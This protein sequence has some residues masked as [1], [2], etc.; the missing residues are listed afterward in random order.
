MMTTKT[1]TFL[2]FL[3][4]SDLTLDYNEYKVDKLAA[5]IV[6]YKYLKL[7]GQKD[8]ELAKKTKNVILQRYYVIVSMLDSLIKE[9]KPSN[10]KLLAYVTQV[11]I[12][13]KDIIAI[14]EIFI[15]KNLN[16]I[17]NQ[18][19]NG[20]YPYYEKSEF[21]RAVGLESV[22]ALILTA[23]VVKP[24]LKNKELREKYKNEIRESMDFLY[25]SKSKFVH[26]HEKIIVAHTFAI[27]GNT[28][29]AAE[30]INNLTAKYE[31]SIFAKHKSLYV[32]NISYLSQIK[33]ILGTDP[34]DHIKWLMN[35]RNPNGGFYSP[36]ETTLAL[37][38][39]YEYEKYIRSKKNHVNNLIFE[40]NGKKYEMSNEISVE[41]IE[42]ITS[43]SKIK[44]SGNGLG[45]ASI[46]CENCKEEVNKRSTIFKGN[47]ISRKLKNNDIRVTSNIIMESLEFINV[48]NLV[49]IEFHSPSG[50]QFTKN[51]SKVGDIVVSIFCLLFE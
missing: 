29:I 26:N 15:H 44:A 25:R 5:S 47:I 45:Y 1:I 30:L 42:G 7:I 28:T 11:L 33:I 41:I 51:S 24:F 37:Q 38:T 18:M 50:Y 8:S 20:S 31:I 19:K 10:I 23:Y 43:T 21:R 12:D 14:E 48:T 9:K 16:Y 46:T 3:F 40:I 36:Y 49:I 35:R 32:E 6:A 22:K 2:L 34:I 17:K 4:H 27:S 13:A 39:F